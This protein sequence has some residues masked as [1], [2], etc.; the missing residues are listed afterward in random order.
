MP[1]AAKCS[2]FY[3][4][5]AGKRRRGL[6]ETIQREMSSLY[7]AYGLNLLSDCPIAGLTPVESLTLE[8]RQVTINFRA[9]N[10]DGPQKAED[11][12]L[13]YTGD[14][15]DE[16]G[17][18]ALTI[19][20]TRSEC[21]YHI[22]YSHGLEFWIDSEANRISVAQIDESC[23]PE[24]AEFLLGPVLGILLR[25]RGVTC[26][27]ASAVAVGEEAIAFVGP[28]GAGKSTTAALFV[29][30]G[31]A[32]LADD[33]VALREGEDSFDAMPGYPRLNLWPESMRILQGNYTTDEIEDSLTEKEQWVLGERGKKF[34]GGRLPLGAVYVFGERS[35]REAPRVE[36]MTSQEA[37]V[38]L[39]ANTYANKLP[40]SK[41]RPREFAFLG[42]L[43][44]RV[45]VRRVI[46]HEDPRRLQELREVILRDMAESRAG[47]AVAAVG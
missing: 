12:T 13:W 4:I 47:T 39:I 29:Q 31:H 19:W 36:G 35:R 25:L 43:V 46:S 6:E 1:Q 11:E 22:R 2:N 32:A 9:C 42:R 7:R 10:L 45:R 5:G 26:L 27:H 33:I 21:D 30:E 44:N 34:C 15:P 18:P 3:S 8:E 23:I 28:A 20:R 37:L 17:N 41:M 16:H 14:I 38:S 40:D 24:A